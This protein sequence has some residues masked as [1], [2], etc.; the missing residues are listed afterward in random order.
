MVRSC[1]I[2]SVVPLLVVVKKLLWLEWMRDNDCLFRLKCLLLLG[3]RVL[4][5]SWNGGVRSSVDLLFL[6][7]YPFSAGALPPSHLDQSSA[8]WSTRY[9][10]GTTTSSGPASPDT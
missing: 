6:A 4:R 9:S 7:L 2:C 8:F 1:T 10:Y 5:G 3:Q